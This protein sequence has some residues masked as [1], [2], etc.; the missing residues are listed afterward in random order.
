MEGKEK[1]QR[2]REREREREGRTKMRREVVDERGCGRKEG[3]KRGEMSIMYKLLCF[4]S[5][6]NLFAVDF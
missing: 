4:R 5:N 6:I 2:E 3:E 1:V